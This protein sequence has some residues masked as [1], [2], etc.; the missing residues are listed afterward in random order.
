MKEPRL[1]IQVRTQGPQSHPATLLACA[2]AAEAAGLDDLYVVDHLAIPPDDAEGSDGRYLDPLGVLLHLAAR[3][4]RIGLGTGVLILPYRPILPTAKVIATLQELSGNRLRLGVGVGWM[5]AE[6]KA[7]GVDRSRRG[8]L[9]DAALEFLNRAFAND[10]VTENGQSFMFLPRPAKPP[11]LIGG[12]P[13][14]AFRRAVQH[15]DGWLPMGGKNPEKFAAPV[16]ELRQR[17]A[18]A[19]KGEPEVVTFTRLPCENPTALQERLAAW[20]DAGMTGVVHGGVR[21]ADVDAFREAALAI[22]EAGL[23]LRSSTPC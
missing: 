19:G 22:A 3:T 12:A 7:L 13:A 18:D 6:F 17:F 2:Q 14:H 8:H 4:R 23:Q 21:Y 11:I 20:A 10:Q 5:E 9:T 1:G 15:G 16:R